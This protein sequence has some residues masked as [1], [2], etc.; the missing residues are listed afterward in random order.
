GSELPRHHPRNHSQRAVP[1]RLTAA[2]TIAMRV[3][4]CHQALDG[5][6]SPDE[7]DVLEQVSAVRAALGSL[8]AEVRI[9]PCGLDLDRVRAQLAEQRPELVFNLVESLADHGGL[10]HVV[11][12]LLD[13]LG[14][15][16]TGASATA[17][18][19]TSNKL[20]ARR[21]GLAAGLPLAREYT[22]G[23]RF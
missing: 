11:P 6:A 5:Q 21:W 19:T 13:A 20:V 16:Y 14:I 1:P 10:I 3:S 4:I 18:F 12:A 8:G 2:G 22:P 23:I 9:L 17:L 15:P 7:L